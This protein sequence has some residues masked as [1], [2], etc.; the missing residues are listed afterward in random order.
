MKKQSDSNKLEGTV[1]SKMSR[2]EKRKSHPKWLV[3]VILVFVS[4]ILTCGIGEAI[5]RQF[6]DK[7]LTVHEEERSLLYRYDELLG[8]FP[9]T[10]SSNAFTGSRTISVFHNSRGFRDIE[11]IVNDK[12]GIM[13]IG[14]SFVWG[15][16]VEQ[17]ERFTEKLRPRISNWDIYNL[18]VSGYATDQEYLLLKQ[19]FSYYRPRVVFLV[20]CTYN[21]D[22]DNTTNTI[23]NGAYYKPYFEVSDQ[24]LVL[25]GVPVPKS[26]TYYHRQHPLLAR[27]YLV[28]L[29]VKALSPEIVR[30]IYPPTSAIL[31][32]MDDFLRQQ[33]SRLVVG[34][35][36]RQPALELFMNNQGIPFIQ[37][38]GAERY[39]THGLHWTPNGHTT[40]SNKIYD[41]LFN[42]GLLE[43]EKK[44]R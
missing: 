9:K 18:G 24:R 16:D 32:E 33:G 7:N 36:D 15:Y 3:N 40:V 39:A 10:N 44:N 34:L 14:D 42:A 43:T 27:S 20:F 4:L 38:T 41:Y 35:L 1:T 25:K 13:F 22:Y 11:Q 19:Q 6:F 12:P 5:I 21:D 30:N 2:Q 8:W 26:L 29:L 31:G 17:S 28:R 23:G 37:L